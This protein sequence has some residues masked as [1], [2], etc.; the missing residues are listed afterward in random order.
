VSRRAGERKTA[1][2]QQQASGCQPVR[3]ELVNEPSA[4]EHVLALQRSAGNRAVAGIGTRALARWVQARAAGPP[5]PWALRVLARHRLTAAQVDRIQWIDARAAGLES[6]LARMR[7]VLSDIGRIQTSYALRS[8]QRQRENWS[9]RQGQ[10]G[11]LGDPRRMNMRPLRISVNPTEIVFRVALQIAAQGVPTRTATRAS[12]RRQL[13]ALAQSYRSEIQ[14]RWALRLTEGY[15]AGRRFRLE[16]TI[17]VLDDPRRRD[18]DHWLILI[19]FDRSGASS[20]VVGTGTVRIPSNH[21]NQPVIVAHEIAHLFGFVDQYYLETRLRG[22]ASAATRRRFLEAFQRGGDEE[23]QRLRERDPEVAAASTAGYGAV[24][25]AR[26]NDLLGAVGYHRLMTPEQR[27]AQADPR[28]YESDVYLLL[29]R[30]QVLER[31]RDQALDATRGSELRSEPA[32]S[33]AVRRGT[34]EL[35]YLRALREAI[36]HGRPEPRRP[37][38]VDERTLIRP[39]RDFIDRIIRSGESL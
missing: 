3:D 26:R 37:P 22:D 25:R 15:Y 18:N 21:V 10:G 16:P 17:E 28:I 34:V 5:G 4:A 24:G 9:E 13:E 36:W 20:G 11:G 38:E 19:E 32:L 23:V 29:D 8:F 39:R 14:V 33:E 1:A 2:S 12:M 6:Q 31:E 30:H 27:R 7:A 35:R